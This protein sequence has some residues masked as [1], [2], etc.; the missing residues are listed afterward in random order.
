MKELN[1][2]PLAKEWFVNQ[3][4]A[5]VGEDVEKVDHFHFDVRDFAQFVVTFVYDYLHNRHFRHATRD[6]GYALHYEPRSVHKII[7]NR[8]KNAGKWQVG[9]KFLLV[10]LKSSTFAADFDEADRCL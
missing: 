6:T 5:F 2:T 7:K 4:I 3:F 1:L 8:S 10:G 9:T